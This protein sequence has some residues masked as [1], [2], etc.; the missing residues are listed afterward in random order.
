MNT[1]IVAP[2]VY[3]NLPPLQLDGLPTWLLISLGVL[4]LILFI[5]FVLFVIELITD[6]RSKK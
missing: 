4:Q 1:L 3:P 2:F 6:S 5:F